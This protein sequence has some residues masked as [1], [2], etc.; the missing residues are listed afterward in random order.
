MR[1]RETRQNVNVSVRDSESA[2]FLREVGDGKRGT[3]SRRLIM[4]EPK[5]GRKPI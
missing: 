3:L 1:I 5:A 4:N 2:T